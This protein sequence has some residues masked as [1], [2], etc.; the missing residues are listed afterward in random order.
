MGKV[1]LP[2]I[3]PMYSM[4]HWLAS[5]G[6]PAKQ[7][8][9]SHN[10]FYNNTVEWGCTRKFLQ[11]FTT[12]EM[13]LHTDSIWSMPFLEKA[14]INTRFARRG[15]LDLIKKMLDDGYYVTFSGVDDYYVKGKS[16][17][18]NANGT[19][20]LVLPYNEVVALA[21]KMRFIYSKFV[22]KYSGKAFEN[23]QICLI[24]IKELEI[25]FLNVFADKLLTELNDEKDS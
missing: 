12:P 8:A 9:T 7:N 5:S 15:A 11:G 20:S 19:T 22:M 4:Y 3:E 24:K 14:G 23:I 13:N 18:K 25:Q 10:W 17:K 16:L 1:E 6:I 2:Y 21:D